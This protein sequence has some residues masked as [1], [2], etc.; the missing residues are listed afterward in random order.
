[1]VPEMAT[2]V[3][4]LFVFML[5]YGVASQSLIDPYRRKNWA[6]FWHILDYIFVL[7]YWQMY[8]DLQLD[9]YIL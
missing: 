7:P 2:F 3:A 6:T 5:I 8:G 9:R 1:M 4:I